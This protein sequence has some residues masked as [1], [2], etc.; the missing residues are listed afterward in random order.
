MDIEH[1]SFQLR[2]VQRALDDIYIQMKNCDRGR[3]WLRLDAPLS[4]DP[5]WLDPD[6]P[7]R[8]RYLCWRLAP[9]WATHIFEDQRDSSL[10]FGAFVWPTD[11]RSNKIKVQSVGTPVV[12]AKCRAFDFRP[13]EMRYPLPD[14]IWEGPA[15]NAKKLVSPEGCPH[16]FDVHAR[17]MLPTTPLAAAEQPPFNVRALAY[18]GYIGP[19]GRLP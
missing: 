11:K 5:A 10:W 2:G 15:R 6:E 9:N 12:S 1:L 7:S 17:F 3:E 18:R 19:Q 14:W 8:L 13:V 16:W 4:L